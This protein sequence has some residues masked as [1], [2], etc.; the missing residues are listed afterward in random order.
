V[1]NG[2]FWHRHDR[3][4]AAV[5][6]SHSEFWDAKFKANEARDARN[7]M[8]LDDLGWRVL[9]VWECETRRPGELRLRIAQWFGL[10]A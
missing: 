9:E 10:A 4:L 2:C 8:L 5:P 7:R 6:K 1:V 3:N